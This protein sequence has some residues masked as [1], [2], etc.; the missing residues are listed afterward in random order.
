MAALDTLCLSTKLAP[1]TCQFTLIQVLHRI[2]FAKARHTDVHPGG[3]GHFPSG[4][5]V[6]DPVEG[7][8]QKA[9]VGSHP[10]PAAPGKAGSIGRRC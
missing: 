9:A 2:G 6:H 5:V 3:V 10:D 4:S 1:L 7:T 8:G